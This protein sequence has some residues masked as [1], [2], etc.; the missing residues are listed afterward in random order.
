MSISLH[1]TVCS[2]IDKQ[3][4]RLLQMWNHFLNCIVQTDFEFIA[5]SHVIRM[6][7]EKSFYIVCLGSFSNIAVP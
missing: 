1:F 4:P 6:D 2:P 5:A 7:I 3:M